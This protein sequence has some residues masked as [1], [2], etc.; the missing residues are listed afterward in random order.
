MTQ[1][2]FDIFLSD[3]RIKE[4]VTDK[5]LSAK[6]YMKY[7][8]IR[9]LKMFK[10]HNLPGTIPQE[11]LEYYLIMNGTAFITKVDRP[12]ITSSKSVSTV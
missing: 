8:T 1:I 10:Y 12:L 11:M 6:S 7:M 4:Y 3:N 9:L 5:R 2:P